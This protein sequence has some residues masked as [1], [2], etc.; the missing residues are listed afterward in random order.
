[1]RTVAQVIA[2]TPELSAEIG[3]SRDLP[4][5]VTALLRGEIDVGFGRVHSVGRQDRGRISSRLARLEPVDVVLSTGHPL[6]GMPGLRPADLRDSVLWSPASLGKLDF[7]PRFAT[8]FA[9]PAQDGAA[10]LGLDHLI[11]HIRANPRHFTL[12]PADIPLPKDA[13]VRPVP[14]TSP[15]P[16]YA[17]SLIWHSQHQHPLLS[18][19]LLRFAWI[20]Q[21]RRWL[22]YDPA[23]DWLPADD[24]AE[25][26]R[27]EHAARAP[28]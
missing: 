23:R 17:W 15:T 26:H 25:L 11:R 13:G 5:T 20:G 24:H 27:P 6:A 28:A 22:E 12:L 1:M 21:E 2:A 18:T 7:L 3:H 14:L 10:N 9:I 4:A 16:L 19:L 8:H